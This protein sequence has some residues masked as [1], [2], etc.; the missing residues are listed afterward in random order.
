MNARYLIILAGPT[1]VGKTNLAIQVAQ[2]LGTEIINADS[3]Q[4]YREMKI[5]TAVPSDQQLAAV[6]HHLVGHK[7]IYE[8]YNASLFERDALQILEKLFSM[9]NSVVMTG[10]SGLYINA[11]C[12]GIDDIPA[13]DL[14][15][16]ERLHQLYIYGGL[17]SLHTMLMNSDPDYYSKVDL[18]NPKRMLKALEIIE[19]TGKPYS[20][21][22]TGSKKSRDFGI[23]RFC[24]D[25]ERKELHRR[26]NQRVDDMM[27]AGLLDEVRELFPNRKLNALN[28]VGYKELIDHLDG[29]CTL[30]E[31][32]DNIKGHTRQYA[33]RQ[34][35]WFRRESDYLWIGPEDLDAVLKQ[36]NEIG[37]HGK[38]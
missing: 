19:M 14:Q 1:A 32:V 6:R 35:T 21:F 24:L 22:L 15:V 27:Y 26:I 5:G 37:Q 12:H 16:R 10:G 4:V 28:T 18:S 31:A 7:S 38:T 2:N 8:P 17:K 36:I 33:R 9:H 11:V 20:S 30:A 25:L 23:I 29:R 13:V 34:L 3:R